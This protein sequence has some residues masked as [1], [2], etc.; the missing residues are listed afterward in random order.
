MQLVAVY[1][2]MAVVLLPLIT[3]F[4]VLNKFRILFEYTLSHTCLQRIFSAMKA[5]HLAE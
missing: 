4:I 1:I 3:R 5:I 2:C